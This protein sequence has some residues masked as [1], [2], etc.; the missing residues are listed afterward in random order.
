MARVL[1]VIGDS[2]QGRRVRALLETA[3]Y[4]VEPLD[5]LAQALAALEA[6]AGRQEC[7]LVLDPMPTDGGMDGFHLLAMLRAS[8]KLAG[9]PCALLMP[10]M[11][12]VDA[13][14]IL[15]GDRGFHVPDPPE[16][17]PTVWVPKSR[18]EGVLPALAHLLLP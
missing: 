6:S 15:Y 16:S 10:R 3:G 13:D 11:P 14:R 4:A 7:V 1:L 12:E 17:P 2:E 5:G 8:P 9:T 18:P